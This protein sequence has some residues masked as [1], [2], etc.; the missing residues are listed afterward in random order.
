[1]VRAEHEDCGARILPGAW[2][3]FSRTPSRVRWAGPN[4]GAQNDLVLG[5]LLGMSRDQ[6]EALCAKGVTADH[7]T[8][9]AR[10]PMAALPIDMS[11]ELGIARGRDPGYADWNHAGSAVPFIDPIP[12]TWGDVA[13]PGK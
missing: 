9:L 11:I 3:R 4:F 6:I 12:L 10:P 13:P 7:P 8:A 5:G 1:F 2:Q